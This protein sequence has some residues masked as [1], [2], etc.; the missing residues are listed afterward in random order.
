MAAD[1]AEDLILDILIHDINNANTIALGY[2]SILESKLKGEDLLYLENLTSGVQQSAGL[3]KNAQT[4][5]KIQK[6]PPTLMGVN[7]AN[8]IKGAGAALSG[9]Q[10]QIVGEPPGKVMA[11]EYLEELFRVIIHN[12]GK[13]AGKNAKVTL[14]VQEKGDFYEV[15]VEDT[16]PGITDALKEGIFNRLDRNAVKKSRKGLGLVLARLIV[17]RY[18]GSIRAEDRVPGKQG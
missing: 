7:L 12:V 10:I 8:V 18:G 3:I 14:R 1:N 6:T 4:I 15:S 2:S 16:G 17:E 11:D 9:H 13:H 5:R